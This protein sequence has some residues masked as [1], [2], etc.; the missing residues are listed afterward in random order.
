MKRENFCFTFD[1]YSQAIENLKIIQNNHLRPI[2]FIKYYQ[3]NKFG[4]DWLIQLKDMLAYELKSKNF[5]IYV[6]ANTNYGLFINLVEKKINF[7]KIKA[8][9]EMRK[10]LN[11]IANLNKVSIN[12]K[13]SVL[14]LSKSKKKFLDLKNFN[15]KNTR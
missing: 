6:D 1:S 2:L 10:K 8:N 5:K 4:I 3:I 7:I 15:K 14:D 13:F 11:H 12:P 9:K